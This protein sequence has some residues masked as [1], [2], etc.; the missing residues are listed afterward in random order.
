MFEI[1]TAAIIT[2]LTGFGGYLF[3]SANQVSKHVIALHTKI[4][5]V[6]QKNDIDTKNLKDLHQLEIKNLNFSFNELKVILNELCKTV[7]KLSSTI[8]VLDSKINL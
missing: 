4:S 1:I 8:E 3:K 7:N 2:I 5:L 6:E